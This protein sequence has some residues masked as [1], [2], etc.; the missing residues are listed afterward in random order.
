MAEARSVALDFSGAQT[1]GVV[2]AAVPSRSIQVLAVV[3][4]CDATAKTVVFK[5]KPSGASTAVSC[6]FTIPASTTVVLPGL[7]GGLGYFASKTGEALNVTTTGTGALG[8]LV[9]YS[10]I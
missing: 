5:S 10:T 6:T 9:L 3:L 4:S 8:V 1:D 2:L 7:D